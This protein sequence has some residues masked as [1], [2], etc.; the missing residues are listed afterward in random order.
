MAKITE[1]PRSRNI[2]QPG[3]T[4]LIVCEGSKT[5]RIYLRN[6]RRR[7]TGVK[8]EIPNTGYTDPLNLLEFAGLKAEEFGINKNTGSVWVVFDADTNSDAVIDKARY[9]A[10]K[11]SREGKYNME[12]ILSNPS[13]ELWYLIH[14][15]S[16]TAALTNTAL[17][18]HL[19]RYL[20]GYDKAMDYFD[21]LKQ[22]QET[23]IA[24]AYSL[25]D[26][27]NG[28]G[29]DLYARA[30]NP[31]THVVRLVEYLNTITGI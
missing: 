20:P 2:R 27:H 6:Y 12:V 17:L 21:C 4:V 19:N 9:K 22:R 24:N 5:E 23:A 30:A 18:Q 16:S 13:F 7:G 10:R 11:I 28:Q 29:R 3:Y 31:S 1:S 26:Y 25:R 14:F 8:I 15:W